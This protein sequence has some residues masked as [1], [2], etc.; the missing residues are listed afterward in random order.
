[1]KTKIKNIIYVN[2]I[3]ILCLIAL[4][5]CKIYSFTGTSLSDDYKTFSIQNFT[6]AVAGGPQNLSLSFNEKIKE[7]YQRNTN[8]KFKSADG[9][10][11]LEGVIIGYELTPVSAT[12]GDKAAMNRLTIAVEVKFFN[13]INPDENFE[14]E[15]SFYQDF[16]QEKSLTEVEPNLVPKILEQLILN[17]FTAT[18]MANSW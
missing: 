9:D 18:T 1:L 14:K 7:Y 10:I 13:K 3:I 6:L 12:A 15:F 11:H 4:N 5:A 17:I 16:S 2:T 8:L